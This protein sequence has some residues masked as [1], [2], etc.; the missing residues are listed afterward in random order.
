MIPKN[1]GE[2]FSSGFLHSDFLGSMSHC[3][4]IPLIVALSVGYSD[5]T[6][7]H[8]WLPIATGNNLDWAEKIPKVAQMTST[9]DIFDAGSGI[10]GPTSRRASA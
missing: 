9:F 3:A 5:I 4:A 6:R 10:S 1:R 8:P 7:F 2:Y